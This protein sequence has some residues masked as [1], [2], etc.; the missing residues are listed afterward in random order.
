M[1]VCEAGRPRKRPGLGRGLGGWWA[2]VAAGFAAIGGFSGGFA[3]RA[4][5]G[6]A[7][8]AP[9]GAESASEGDGWNGLMVPAYFGPDRTE[10]WRALASAAGRV[11]LVAIGN[12]FN[13][14]G[15]ARR[16]DYRNVFDAVRSGGGRVL[17]YVHTTYTRRPAAEVRADI[18]RWFE[19][20]AVDGIFVDEMTN[21]GTSAGLAYY[22]DLAQVAKAAYPGALV[23]GNPGTTTRESYRTQGAA[24]VLVT[25]EH[26]TGYATYVPDAWTRRHPRS[27]FCHLG[28][29]VPSS[30][31]MTRFAGWA[32]ERRAGWIY[33]TDDA[34]PNPWDRLPAYWDD[35]VAIVRESNR[36]V[37]VRLTFVRQGS[38]SATL[39]AESAPGRYVVQT[40]DDLRLWHDWYATAAATGRVE[41]VLPL[42]EARRFV[43]VSR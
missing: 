41:L 3:A 38:D 43:R 37:V 16:E 20:Y 5:S 9:V 8:A 10:A 25:F 24:D 4:A 36:D 21:D 42:R 22:R 34:L 31:E 40:S 2:W 1:T 17:G 32:R 33:F 35:E 39:I 19:F 29:Q 28:Y 30:D 14:P 26:H 15:I 6:V 23:V 7:E 11:P 27:G 18:A 12:V 13:G